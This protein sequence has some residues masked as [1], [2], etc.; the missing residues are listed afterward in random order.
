MHT[1]MHIYS[2]S[3]FLKLKNNVYEEKAVYCERERIF[4]DSSVDGMSH[5]GHKGIF[6]CPV[7]ET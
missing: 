3:I 5:E 4:S 7:K 2:E 1:H 6:W